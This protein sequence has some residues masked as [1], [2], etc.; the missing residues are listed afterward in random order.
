M[1]LVA[2]TYADQ[3]HWKC[4]AYLHQSVADILQA[5]P[6]VYLLDDLA[7]P[8]AKLVTPD[9]K[10][11]EAADGRD[12]FPLLKTFL[13]TKQPN[14]FEPALLFYAQVPPPTGK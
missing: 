10:F 6:G 2:I 11:R 5:L 7:R 4:E 1:Q 12:T 13:D 8:Q 3:M 9:V 14:P